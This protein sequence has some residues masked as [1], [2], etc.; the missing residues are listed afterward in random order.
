MEHPISVV[1]LAPAS[2]LCLPRTPTMQS[3]TNRPLLPLLC[4]SAEEH[5]GHARTKSSQVLRAVSGSGGSALSPLK[6]A[7][8]SSK[9]AEAAAGARASRASSASRRWVEWGSG[10]GER[11]EC[12]DRAWCLVEARLSHG[13]GR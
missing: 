8:V 13:G 11:W 12:V 9:R 10:E 5:T 7:K 2:F 6:S 3:P 4:Y 1:G